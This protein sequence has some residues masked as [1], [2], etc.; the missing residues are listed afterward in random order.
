MERLFDVNLRV[1]R[2]AFNMAVLYMILIGFLYSLLIAR[3]ASSMVF[4]VLLYLFQPFAVFGAPALFLTLHE[5]K[6]SEALDR[7][8]YTPPGARKR[9]L[10]LTAL[11]ALAA[12]LFYT[13]LSFAAEGF[14]AAATGGLSLYVPPRPALWQLFLSLAVNAVFAAFLREFVFRYL[15]RKAYG[16][17]VWGIACASVLSALVS[18]DLLIALR[19]F[20]LGAASAAVFCGT[21]RMRFCF[22]FAFVFEGLQTIV[23]SYWTLP[24]S[25]YASVSIETSLLYG[26]FSAAAAL[27]FAALLYLLFR[28]LRFQPAKGAFR[29]RRSGVLTFALC[30]AAFIALAIWNKFI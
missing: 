2:P 22:L 16:R 1:R 30:L 4:I 21:K 7:N 25:T 24:L 29:F 19:L 3:F 10:F 15:G 9:D 20:V 11:A 12:W 17:T 13:Y 8:V 27:V 18:Y 6:Y 14:R 23:P 26:L 28:C 5:K